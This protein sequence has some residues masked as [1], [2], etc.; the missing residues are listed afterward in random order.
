[1]AVCQRLWIQYN[2]KESY[3]GH[4][5]IFMDEET[6]IPKGVVLPIFAVFSVVWLLDP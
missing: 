6:L 4:E 2:L 3:S 5:F 1:M